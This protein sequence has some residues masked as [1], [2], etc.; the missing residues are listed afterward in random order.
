MITRE[1]L[2]DVALKDIFANEQN[3]RVNDEAVPAVIASIQASD[4]ITPII[5]DETNKILAGNTRYKALLQMGKS[6]IPMVIRISGLTED[7]KRR[8]ILADNK[9]QEFAEWDWEKLATFTEGLL[10]DVGFTDAEID[11]IL[12]PGKDDYKVP[13]EVRENVDIRL[14]DLIQI[15]DHRLVCGD[16]RSTE[17]YQ[18]LFA[19]KRASMTFTDLPYNID[20]HGGISS[21]GSSHERDSIA[22][23]NMSE[24]DFYKFLTEMLAPMMAY[25]EGCFYLCMSSKEIG[26]L[27]KAFEVAGGHWQANIIWAKNTFTLSRSD[28]QNQY[29]PI[30]YGWNDKAK[31][32]YFAGWRTEGNV[33]EDLEIVHPV[34]DGKKTV[35]RIGEYH[36][37]IEGEVKGK[38]VNKRG[39]T[40]IWREKKLSKTAWH[41]NQ[42]P[43]EI[44]SK[45]IR[46][47]SRRGEIVLDS[48]L[49]GGSTLIAAQAESRVCYGIEIDP[50]YIDASMRRFHQTWPDMP[51]LCNGVVY[52]KA[53]LK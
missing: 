48:C 50:R 26:P 29:E 51:M 30:L 38:I 10:E 31:N 39:E 49:G 15:G 47:S 28:W 53:K 21:D 1:T 16:S 18:K 40:D 4:Y 41:P 23:D 42:K 19:D 14:G 34:F 43:V 27:K 25:C 17:I 2:S 11:K 44:C 46:A 45:A 5:V 20:Y 3:P 37:E 6:L 33:W 9:T 22:N 24:E 35:I 12:R 36:I 32:H 7:Q 8:Y 13:V 52:D